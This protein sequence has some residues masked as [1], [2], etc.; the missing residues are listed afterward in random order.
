M[1]HNSTCAEW[2]TLNLMMWTAPGPASGSNESCA[3]MVVVE[4]PSEGE[5]CT[6]QKR[7]Q[8]LHSV[9]LEDHRPPLMLK[10]GAGPGEP[11][12]WI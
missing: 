11:S 9:D 8:A 1:A 10:L 5:E 3:K 4:Q 7:L 6:R 2:L 12:P